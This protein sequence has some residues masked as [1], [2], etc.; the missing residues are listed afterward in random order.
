[1]NV[2][3]GAFWKEFPFQCQ[4]N[5][6]LCTFHFIRFYLTQ[7]I[8]DLHP[9]LIHGTNNKG[10]ITFVKE[11]LTFQ[12]S[13][14]FKCLIFGLWR[15]GR[16]LS[17][18]YCVIS[19]GFLPHQLNPPCLPGHGFG[20]SAVFLIRAAGEQSRFHSTK[21]RNVSARKVEVIIS[22]SVAQTHVLLHC[23]RT[24]MSSFP[25][26]VYIHFQLGFYICFSLYIFGCEIIHQDYYIIC[27]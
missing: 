4:R 22:S 10:L 17:E 25:V 15:E 14:F 7:A 6:N 2:Q 20:A 13:S 9:V 11:N 12:S 27:V 8:Y 26:N 23:A 3:S 18:N 21:L 5:A 16:A 24:E 19:A 1:M